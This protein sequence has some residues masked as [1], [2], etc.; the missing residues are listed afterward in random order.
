MTCPTV[1]DIPRRRYRVRASHHPAYLEFVLS[2]WRYRWAAHVHAW[3]WVHV[4]G[5]GQ[6]WP[7]AYVEEVSP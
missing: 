7:Y 4:L 1:A 5:D 6:L 3:L 2:T